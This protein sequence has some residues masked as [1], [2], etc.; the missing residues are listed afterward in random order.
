MQ[1]LFLSI[2]LVGVVGLS[3]S[4]VAGAAEKSAPIKVL[5]IAG[6]DVAPYHDWREISEKTREVLAGCGRF[7]VKVCED[8]LILESNAALNAYD[9]LVWTMFHRGT[10][11]MTDMAKTNLVNFVKNGKGFYVQHL[12]SA[13]FPKWDEFGKL[14]GRKW[15]MGTSGH[16]PRSVFE[17]KVVKKNHP[18]TEGM[19][20]FKIFDELYSKLQGDKDI[21]VL[22]SAYSDFSEK[23][24]PLVFTTPYG[25][26]RCV[27]NA[28]GH[29]FK[30]ILNPSMAQL[31]CRS[32][33]WAATGKV[34]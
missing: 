24:E 30:S 20:N 12:G 14:C 5:L 23:E 6:D 31:I 34:Q 4:L 7:D 17:V 22:V 3:V 27:H 15:V 10:P 9:V 8:P 19:A 25:Q 11:A 32:V 33:E 26:G 16:G 21:E 13:S 2:A 29:D 28:L 18:I 1:R